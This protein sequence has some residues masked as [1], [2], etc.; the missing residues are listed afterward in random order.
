MLSHL[1]GGGTSI[2]YPIVLRLVS[3]L[4]ATFL[5]FS[6]AFAQPAL[7]PDDPALLALLHARSRAEDMVAEGRHAQAITTLLQS[8]RDAPDSRPALA[9]AAYGNGQMISYV[10]LHL[11]PEPEAYAFAEKSFAV[12]TYDVDRMVQTLCYIAIG[13]NSEDKTALSVE[14][15]YLTSSENKLVRAITLYFLSLPYF[16]GATDFTSQ[17]AALL[18]KEFPDLDLSQTALTLPLYTSLET[19]DFDQVAAG[20]L[21]G[22]EKSTGPLLSTWAQGVRERLR[23]SGENISAMKSA[24]SSRAQALRPLLDGISNATSWQ[25]RYFSL[26]LTKGEFSGEAGGAMRE[27]ARRVASSKK[28]TPEVV[29]A[30]VELIGALA[31]DCVSDPD[32]LEKR[33]EAYALAREVLANGVTETTPERV[34]W[35]TWIYGLQRAAAGLGEA[36]HVEEALAIYGDLAARLP[37]SKVAAAC[38]SAM[39]ALQAGGGSG[40]ENE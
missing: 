24:E 36:G 3:L 2:R 5:V 7:A 39:S 13:L 37:G 1:P 14:A 17:N 38:Q 18:A 6:P 12:D 19:E 8:L 4:T 40:S 10:L 33:D 23:A 29:L 25:E 31:G 26:L 34:L 21:S 16:Y 22:A 11:M 28:N 30:R 27:A 35:E 32:D 15:S 9:D 20:T